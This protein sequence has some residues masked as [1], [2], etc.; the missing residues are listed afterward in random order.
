MLPGGIALQVA[1]FAAGIYFDLKRPL[2]KWTH[3]QQAMKSN[4]NAGMGIGSSAGIVAIIAA[5]CAL[6]VLRGISP[7]LIGCGAAVASIVLASV[8]LRR[9]LAFADRQY[10]GGLEM[11]G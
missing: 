2:L 10:G 11:E 1:A 9:L 7:F 8:L 5:P 6:L 3:P 4:M